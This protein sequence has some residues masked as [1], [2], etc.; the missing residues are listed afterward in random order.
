VPEIAQ[1]AQKCY[2]IRQIESAFSK[3]TPLN[4]Q[5]KNQLKNEKTEIQKGNYFPITENKCHSQL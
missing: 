1:L 3:K 5:K 4:L 2:T